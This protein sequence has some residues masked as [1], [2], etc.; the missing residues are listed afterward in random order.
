MKP[1]SQF[2]SG[3]LFN[4]PAKFRLRGTGLLSRDEVM[5]LAQVSEPT[6]V[7]AVRATRCRTQWGQA[8]IPSLKA[9]YINGALAFDRNDV[10]GWMK[11]RQKKN[12]DV[13]RPVTTRR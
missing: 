1:K 13:S 11:A 2:A 4:K 5:A 3:G 12:Q 9:T 8:K 10:R 6:L 7:R